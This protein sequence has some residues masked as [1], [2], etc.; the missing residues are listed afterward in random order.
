MNKEYK[1]K[2]WRIVVKLSATFLLGAFI[3]TAC[4][5]EDTNLGG[6]INPNGLNIIKT[7]TITVKTYS[8]ELDSLETDE[9]SI[10]FRITGT[11][12]G[13]RTCKY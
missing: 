1:F 8:S 6:E 7:D 11:T 5:K 12:Q 2:N 4:K 9:T 10:S 3:I 13:I